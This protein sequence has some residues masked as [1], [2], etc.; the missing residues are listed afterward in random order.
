MAEDLR[1]RSGTA[2][3]WAGW[4]GAVYLGLGWLSI[5]LSLQPGSIAALWYPNAVGV[6][7]LTVAPA[8][9]RAAV[10]AVIAVAGIFANAPVSQDLLHAFRLV[11][12]N[13]VEIALAAYLLRRFGLHERDVRSPRRLGALLVWGGLLPSAVGALAGAL[14]LVL[15]DGAPVAEAWLR[16]FTGSSLGALAV[17]PLAV[18]LLTRPGRELREELGSIPGL[19]LVL[20]CAGVAVLSLAYLPY[21]FVFL[22]VPLLLAAVSSGQAASALA[23]LVVSLVFAACLALGVL[24][25]PPVIEAWQQMYVYL[26]CAAALIPVHLLA[27]AMAQATDS[28]RHLEQRSLELRHAHDRLEQ[29]VRMASHDM[30]EPLNTVT[31]FS[32]LI[33]EESDRLSPDAQRYLMLVTRSATRMRTLLDDVLRYAQLHADD[34]ASHAP[35]ALD[36]LF[37]ELRMALAARIESSRATLHVA[38]MPQVL[39]NASLLSLMFQNLLANALKFVPP[40]RAPV[41]EVS[42]RQEGDRVLVAVADNGI[43]IAEGDIGKLF[44]P[45]Q[46]LHLRRKFDGTGLGLALSRQIAELHGGRITVQSE[47]DRGSRFEVSLPAARVVDL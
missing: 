10:L 47:P 45:F 15:V 3:R 8:H 42:V 40:G 26:A 37:E 38:P 35:V 21:P 31:Q 25:P 34:P 30:R 11:P 44:R 9:A 18:Q 22:V 43:G 17:L 23:A 32:G 7:V 5:A 13:M 27:S 33:G 4:T 28:R 39:G 6:A 12:A 46:R 20:V 14:T 41:I 36:D 2:W 24:V 29:F 1:G 16:W 19:S